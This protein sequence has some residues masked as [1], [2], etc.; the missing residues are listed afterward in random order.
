MAERPFYDS[1]YKRT[2]APT[3]TLTVLR[4][5]EPT[6]CE[7][8]GSETQVGDW[9]WC[10]GDPN[11]HT[12]GKFGLDP[13]HDYIDVGLPGENKQWGIDNAGNPA[14][15]VR[16]SSRDERNAIMREHGLVSGGKVS[17]KKKTPQDFDALAEK[18]VKRAVETW[19][20]RG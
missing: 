17:H 6:I 3:E 14:Y 8:C 4:D 18:I 11:D 9:P 16:I 10:K 7:K 5:P 13:L 19:R 2:E 15:G 20:Q 12:A 1:S